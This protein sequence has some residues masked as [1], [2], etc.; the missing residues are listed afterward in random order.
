MIACV[1]LRPAGNR[2]E[3]SELVPE[4]F[5]RRSTDEGND[6]RSTVMADEREPDADDMMTDRERD[7]A[8][9]ALAEY[10]RKNYEACLQ[11]LERIAE[12]RPNDPKVML[13]KA[14]VEF[15]KNGSCTTD[16]YRK[17]FADVCEQVINRSTMSVGEFEKLLTFFLCL[18]FFFKSPYNLLH[19]FP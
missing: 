9:Q 18:F 3:L 8:R 16:A 19:I 15:Y 12:T 6:L 5:R 10:E 11:H 4:R 7:L 2:I 14:V 1:H 17:A 13:N